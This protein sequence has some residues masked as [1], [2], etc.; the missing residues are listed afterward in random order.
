[1]VHRVRY[2]IRWVRWVHGLIANGVSRLSFTFDHPFVTVSTDDDALMHR[3]IAV[4]PSLGIFRVY[5]DAF[6]PG[7][8]VFMKA[9][10]RL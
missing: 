8:V 2:F 3:R 10:R 6:L 5:H 9:C 4:P 1:M 7:G